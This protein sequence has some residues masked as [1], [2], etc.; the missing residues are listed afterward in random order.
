MVLFVTGQRNIGKTTLIKTIQDVF[1]K[2]TTGFSTKEFFVDN[3]RAG[4][5]LTHMNIPDIPTEDRI[6]ATMDK[7]F[8]PIIREQTFEAYGV[9]LCKKLQ[10]S[11]KKICMIDEIGTFEQYCEGYKQELQHTLNIEGKIIIAT[12]RQQDN[13]FLNELKEGKEVVTLTKENR[14][15]ITQCMI[16]RIR[17]E[18]N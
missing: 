6:I 12:I 4:F 14:D 1:W 16:E 9:K 10:N 15:T 18:L 2:E 11:N 5:Y 8:R 7:N 13:I 17:K 3:K